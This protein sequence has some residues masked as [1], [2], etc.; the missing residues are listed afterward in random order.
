MGLE[1]VDD[2]TCVFVFSSKKDAREAFSRL[3][4][5]D[6]VGANTGAESNSDDVAPM[7]VDDP[8]DL[9]FISARPFPVALWPPEERINQSLGQGR[10]LKGPIRMR[11]ARV[12]DVK[13]KGANRTSQFY[14]KH[15]SKAG[16][17]LF[18]GRDLPPAQPS[19]RKRQEFPLDEERRRKELD[20]QL[21]DFL[22]EDEA[23]SDA[24]DTGRLGRK[25]ARYHSRSY[26]PS[27]TPPSAGPPPSP[28]SKMRSDYIANDGRTLLER[29]SL[30]RYHPLGS[31][32]LADD[33][34][35]DAR[36]VLPLP[37]RKRGGRGR[38]FGEIP[39]VVGS[40]SLE[41]RIRSTHEDS[42]SGV[43]WDVSRDKKRKNPRERK[44]KGGERSVKTQQ[45][46]DDEL[47]AFLNGND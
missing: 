3:T 6:A 15:G 8:L 23:N 13:K 43:R 10:G 17:E 46:L 14:K 27:R 19:K 35:S 12:D 41:N 22:A 11:W 16:K 21:D 1:W 39:S 38:K 29:T 25:R 42:D 45:E 24:E 28:P 20:K 30:L 4:K 31:D 33:G 34:S 36:L 18:N 44:R 47:D 7:S 9:D 40:L 37:R 32:P 2:R 5:P 26:S